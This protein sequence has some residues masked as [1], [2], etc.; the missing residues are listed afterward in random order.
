[1]FCTLFRANQFKK[2]QKILLISDRHC[3]PNG[4]MDFFWQYV[5]TSLKFNEKQAFS[6]H[7]TKAFIACGGKGLF[8]LSG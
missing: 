2:L 5:Y 1:M 3:K 8:V 4:N 7:K 6:A